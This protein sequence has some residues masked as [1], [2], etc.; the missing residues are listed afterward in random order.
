MTS[1]LD[2]PMNVRDSKQYI[3]FSPLEDITAYELAKVI[4]IDYTAVQLNLPVEECL[5]F[6]EEHDIQR[7]FLLDGER[8]LVGDD[9]DEESPREDRG[10]SLEW[11]EDDNA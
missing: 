4:Q 2:Y 5:R 11:H 10:E 1:L 9:V 7:H 3:Q 8:L 6:I